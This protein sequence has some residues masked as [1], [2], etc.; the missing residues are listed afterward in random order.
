MLLGFRAATAVVE[1]KRGGRIYRAGRGRQVVV[2]NSLGRAE[3]RFDYAVVGAHADSA[4]G[5]GAGK[6]WTVVVQ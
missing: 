2:V 5:F 6:G 4:L 3:I 1:G